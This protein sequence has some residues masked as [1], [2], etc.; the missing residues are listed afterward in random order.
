MDTWPR[1]S[2]V[3]PSYNQGRFIEATLR[4]LFDQGYPNLEVLLIDGGSTD[5]TI[6]IVRRYADRLAYWV[7]EPDEGRDATR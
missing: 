1:I 6:E 4:S 5:N 3:I 7:S 2:I